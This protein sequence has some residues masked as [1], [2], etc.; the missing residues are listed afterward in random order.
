MS[1]E[2]NKSF[3]TLA[4]IGGIILFSILLGYVTGTEDVMWD[5]LG[6]IG[7]VLVGITIL[8]TVHE[9]GHF[10]PAKLFGIKVEIFSIGFPPRLFGFRRGE[11]EY[12]VGA[13]PLGGYVKIAGMIDESLDQETIRREKE[14]FKK[15]QD[16]W[17]TGSEGA[18]EQ[19]WMPKPWEFRAKPVWQR[20]IVM[21]G[22]VIMNVILG[23]FIISMLK[24][25]YGEIRLPMSEVKYGIQVIEP[26]YSVEEDEDTGEI[27][28]TLIQS[29]GYLIGFRTGDQVL[30]FKGKQFEFL[31]DYNNQKYLLED[32]A[33]F[34]VIREDGTP[35]TVFVPGDIQN[36]FSADTIIPTLF[37]PAAPSEVI[38]NPTIDIPDPTEEDPENIRSIESPASKAGLKTGDVIVGLDSMDIRRFLDVSRFMDGKKSDTIE[39]LVLRSGQPLTFTVVSTQEGYLGVRR[40]DDKDIFQ[41]DTLQYGF[42][43]SFVPGSREAFGF[44]STNVKGFQ[45][46]A[47]EGVEIRKSLM[48]PIQI[49]KVYLDA[50]KA[51]GIEFFFRLTGMLS[52]ILALVNILPIPALDGG[53][54]IFLLIEAITRREPSPK[55]RI[56]AQQIGFVLILGLMALVLLNDI[57]RVIG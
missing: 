38:V 44:V 35:D 19:D 34:G 3:K 15:N 45:N 47:R 11:T 32:N 37:F 49:A 18:A 14:R 43:E 27:D 33:W 25:S 56:I 9:M 28:S 10:L 39:V 53:H 48:G 42:F 17:K 52:M 51:G 5:I 54:V 29:L 40:L 2:R 7:L 21:T 6:A 55:V 57:T 13:T 46:T 20:L 26:Q 23:I 30:S 31:G 12:Q 41:Y 22:G 24:Y 8:V 16:G 50:F 4:I 1:Q 36:Y